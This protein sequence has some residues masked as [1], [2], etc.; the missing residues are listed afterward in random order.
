MTKYKTLSVIGGSTLGGLFI[1]I[2]ALVYFSLT[3]ESTEK[4]QQMEPKE[5]D[6]VIVE[7]VISLPA[8][9]VFVSKP[10]TKKH[11]ADLPVKVDGQK[12]DSLEKK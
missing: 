1:F 12:P 2:S 11:C 7:K 6:T 4:P 3:R 5:R 8:D 10:C 9:T